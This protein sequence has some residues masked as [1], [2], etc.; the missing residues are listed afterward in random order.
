[1]LSESP[2]APGVNGAAA[3]VL[4]FSGDPKATGGLPTFRPAVPGQW[5]AVH[6]QLIFRP[7]GAFPPGAVIT[8][9]VRGGASGV[10]SVGGRP[11]VRGLVFQFG[12]RSGSVRRAQQILSLLGYLPVHFVPAIHQVPTLDDAEREMYVPPQGLFTWTWDAPS[13]LQALFVEGDANVLFRGALMS[14][15]SSHGLAVTGTLGPTVWSDLVRASQHLSLWRN[16]AG[17]TYAL[18]DKNYPETLTVWHDN[19]VLLVSPANTGGDLTPTEDGNF[20]VY[21]RLASQVM[22]GVNPDGAPY[23]DP[24]AWV[25]YFNGGDAVHYIDRED[26]GIPQSLGCVELPYDQAEFIWPYLTIG[27]IVTVEQ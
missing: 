9:H 3:I 16:R 17:Y 27:T 4:T 23:A 7:D 26:Y 15:E 12:T 24:V 14:F 20:P 8:V 18:A 11:L 21:L 22:T 25:A 2:N 5:Y 10:T 1:L 13:Q 19:K 6:N